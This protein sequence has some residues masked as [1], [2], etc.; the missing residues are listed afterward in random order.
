MATGK[1]R[2]LFSDKE[3]TE[4]LFPRTKV[5][6]ISDDNGNGLAAV[7]DNAINDAS[8]VY[9]ATGELPSP[10]ASRYKMCIKSSGVDTTI[11]TK[12]N[13]SWV[14]VSSFSGV[15]IGSG[16][17]PEGYNVQID[18][19]G[20]ACEVLTKDDFK[21]EKLWQ[22]ASPASS[23]AGQTITPSKPITEYD[24]LMVEF[25]FS[26]SSPTR[27]N[28]Q[29]M[30]ATVG[31]SGELIII[32]GA[33]GY[34]G[35]RYVYL[36]EASEIYFGPCQYNVAENNDYILPQAIYGIKGVMS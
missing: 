7:I 1:I 34:T 9:V 25:G 30:T 33:N 6:A 26:I 29:I 13:N 19:T 2:T 3:K 17:M 14:Q 4:V 21:I 12:V 11:Y 36:E 24:F 5:S 20:E 27:I 28:H 35:V 16:D 18:P 10:T 15:Y 23:F 22:N 31:N 8:E 32:A